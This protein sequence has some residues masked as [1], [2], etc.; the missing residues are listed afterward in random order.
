MYTKAVV[1]RLFQK[2]DILPPKPVGFRLKTLFNIVEERF[3]KWLN[4]DVSAV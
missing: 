3:K 2:M 4:F 1:F